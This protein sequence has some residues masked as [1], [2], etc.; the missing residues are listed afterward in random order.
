MF[1][2]MLLVFLIMGLSDI[3]V[4]APCVTQSDRGTENFNVAY[5]HTHIRHSLDLAFRLHPTPM[6]A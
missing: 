1:G 2:G 3:Y 4:G 6:G 5:A